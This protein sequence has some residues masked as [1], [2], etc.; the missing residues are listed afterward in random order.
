MDSS[1]N[2]IKIK[3]EGDLTIHHYDDDAVHPGE[4]DFWKGIVM[5]GQQVVARSF[6]WAPTLVVDDLPD[7]LMYTPLFEGTIVRFYTHN[8]KPMV[9]TYRQIDISNKNSRVGTGKPFISLIKDAISQWSYSQYSYDVTDPTY[10]SGPA[11]RGFAYT[12]TSWEEL[13]VPGWCHVFI[14]IDSSNQITDLTDLSETFEII[15]EEGNEEITTFTSPKLLHAISFIEDTQYMTPYTGQIIYNSV[16]TNGE[17]TQHTWLLPEIQVMNRDAAEE[18]LAD[19][20]AVVGFNPM[21]PD[22]TTKFL[23]YE[24]NRK[25]ELAG[26]TFNPIHRWHQLMD[27]SVDEANEYISNLPYEKKHISLQ[28]MVEAHN[29]YIKK[30]VDTFAINVTDRFYGRHAQM[31]KRLYDK[32]RD[33]VG[34]T[35]ITLRQEYPR[36]K[37]KEPELFIRAKQLILDEISKMSYTQQHTIHGLILR[38]ESGH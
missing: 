8:G 15:N 33:I 26:K 21:Y 31:D 9:G 4:A 3:Q 34:D 20:G 38:S 1:N 2:I 25:L 35:L 28:D 10:L 5:D 16:Q 27:V 6:Q 23:S 32:Y 17:H 18:T 19:D 24:Y 13:C 22:I 30:I 7:N 36:N 12:P 14:L 11:R 29:R 37:P